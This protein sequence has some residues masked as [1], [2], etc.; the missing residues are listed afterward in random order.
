[1]EVGASIGAHRCLAQHTLQV[2]TISV[3]TEKGERPMDENTAQAWAQAFEKMGVAVKAAC[4]A[5]IATGEAIGATLQQII[6]AGY[7]QNMVAQ[8]GAYNA[9]AAEHPDWAHRAKY[10]KKKRIRK[11]YHDRI[12]R[13]Y[14][15]A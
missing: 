5:I 15:R 9:A 11:K 3:P 10:A 6:D 4:D 14:G 2:Q 8:I 12:M 13:E 7:L 1:M